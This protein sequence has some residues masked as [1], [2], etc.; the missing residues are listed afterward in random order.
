MKFIFYS[1]AILKKIKTT[2]FS[3]RRNHILQIR[4]LSK[5]IGKSYIYFNNIDLYMF[6]KNLATV[7]MKHF[8]L[9]NFIP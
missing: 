1:N 2:L 3:S 9:E 4:R 5:Q 6:V 7:S 8:N